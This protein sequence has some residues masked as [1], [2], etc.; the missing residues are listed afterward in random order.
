MRG[1]SIYITLILADN[2]WSQ[3]RL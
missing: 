1:Y 2:S 3:S